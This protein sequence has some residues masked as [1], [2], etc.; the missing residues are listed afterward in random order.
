[1]TSGNF[2]AMNEAEQRDLAR[3]LWEGSDVFD[4]ETALELV[5]RRPEKA[6]EILQMRA[7]T[8]RRQEERAR[9]REQLRQAFIEDFG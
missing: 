8:Q 6:R 4:F 1:M 3:R 5:Q 2:E 7:D 9:G